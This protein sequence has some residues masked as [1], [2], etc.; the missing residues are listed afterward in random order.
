MRMHEE[1]QGLELLAGLSC[2]DV[3]HRTPAEGHSRGVVV[4]RLRPSQA[5]VSACLAHPEHLSH[6]EAKDERLAATEHCT[7][8]IALSNY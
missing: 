2:V 8:L 6:P 1:V 4:G 3:H 7:T 5:V